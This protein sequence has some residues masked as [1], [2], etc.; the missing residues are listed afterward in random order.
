MSCDLL[1]ACVFPIHFKLLY[2]MMTPIPFFV[3]LVYPLFI[4]IVFTDGKRLTRSVEDETSVFQI[5][6][7][8]QIPLKDRHF[9]GVC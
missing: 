6:F 8:R 1:R 2:I 4:R 9:N 7:Q 3:P 5:A